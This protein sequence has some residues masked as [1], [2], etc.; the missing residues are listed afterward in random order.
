M[1]KRNVTQL[2]IPGSCLCRPDVGSVL[3]QADNG[4]SPLIDHSSALQP[5]IKTRFVRDAWSFFSGKIVQEDIYSVE[6][7][8]RNSGIL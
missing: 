7:E 1:K 3:L 2:H 5:R 8:G 4:T 6:P